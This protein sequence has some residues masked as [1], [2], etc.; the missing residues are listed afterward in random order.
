MFW[1]RSQ[2][3]D[4]SRTNCLTE[5]FFEEAIENARKLDQGPSRGAWHGIPV[6]LKDQFNVKGQDSTIG[7]VARVNYPATKNSAIVESILQQG[8]IFYCKT[9]VPQ[10]VMTADTVSNLFGR[11]LNPVNSNIIPSGSSGGEAALLACHGSLIG[12]GTDTGGSIRNPAA[13][14]EL[15]G[16]KPSSGRVSY[17]DVVS[18]NDGNPLVTT[19]AG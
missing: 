10:T 11:T 14:C 19:V 16:L 15:Y 4:P 1:S 13:A 12:I 5:I 3:S 8:G 17:K 2:V 7:Y 6:S 18:S 9:T